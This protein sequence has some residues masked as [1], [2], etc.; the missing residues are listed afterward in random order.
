MLGYTNYLTDPRPR[1][2]A[3]ALAE[4]GDVVDFI[5]LAEHGRPR[6]EIVNNVRLIRLSQVRYRGESGIRY[7]TGYLWFFL[8]AMFRVT[9][10]YVQ[11]NYDVIYVH[12]MPDFMVFVALIPKLFGATIVLNMHDTMPELYMSKFG[13]KEE[14]YLIRLI[15][16]QEKI[17]FSFAD[18]IICVHEPHKQLLVRRGAKV[19]RLTVLMN[20]PDP[21]IFGE[22]IS[23]TA[24]APFD[25]PLRL[26]YH[27]TIARRLGLDTALYAFKE[28][29]L[30][31]PDARFDIYG[32]GDFADQVM[33]LILNLEL[34][35]NVNFSRMFF[36][37]GKI[38]AL[39]RGAT[40]GII[41]NRRDPAT[42]YMLPVKLLE[43]LYLGIPVVSPDLYVIR[44]YFDST[45]VAF[46]KSDDAHDLAETVLK[47]F[48]SPHT[49]QSLIDHAGHVLDAISWNVMKQELYKLIDN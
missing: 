34:S 40:I 13:M 47:L 19:D 11:K 32:D 23:I 4:R 43:Y 14:Q 18:K 1:R 41:P 16:I 42:E 25:T 38:P 46:Y 6:M 12:T 45:S 33:T 15:K 44:Y 5:S 22:R 10:F 21:R 7:L 8:V 27:G 28:I 2:E 9:V 36:D 17:S 35:Q 3:E 31:Y 26:I 49:R 30:K 29:I 20:V 24:K 39:I 37:I 48:A